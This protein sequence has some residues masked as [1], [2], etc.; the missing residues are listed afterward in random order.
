MSQPLAAT[1]DARRS[2]FA[3][4]L[5]LVILGLEL[6]DGRPG[7]LVDDDVWDLSGLAGVPVQLWN[8][9]LRWD[10][11][12]I[13]NPAWRW[14][15]RELLIAL[16]A[17]HDPRVE[18]LPRANRTALAP[19][20]CKGRFDA[21]VAWLN[22]L[23]AE[24]VSSLT[25]VDQHDCD[26][27][28][29][30]EQRRGLQESSVVGKI[31]AVID[32][33]RYGPLFS[34]DRYADG[35]VPWA[36]R[37]PTKVAGYRR[38]GE[39]RTPPV[40]DEIH[41][42]LVAAAR[43]IVE[44]IGPQ[45]AQ[46]LDERPTVLRAGG[47]GATLE[48]IRSYITR[49]VQQGSACSQI[50]A[51]RLR[52]RLYL[53]WHPDDPLLRLGFGPMRHELGCRDPSR[54][55]IEEIRAELEAAVAAV[56]IA[57]PL[58]RDAATVP[59]ADGSSQITWTEPLTHRE[60]DGLVTLTLNACLV[61]VAAISGMRSGELMELTPGS[62]LPPRPTGPGLVRYALR[63]RRIKGAPFGGIDDEWIVIEPA[64][65]AVEL[66]AGLNRGE[67]DAP[68]FGRFHFRT[69]LENF[70]RWVNSPGG[71]RLGLAPIPDGHVT[72]R[73]L[74]RTLAVE[75]AHRPHGLFAA[76]LH[77]KHISVAT[78]EG[79]AGRPGGSQ[80]RFHAEVAHE[81]RLHREAL[82]RAAFDEFREGRLP[83]GPGAAALIAAFREVDAQLADLK[84]TQPMIVATDRQI[85]LL[86]Q[87]KAATLYAQ[88]ANYCWF[89]DP[90]KALCLKIAGRPEAT[91]PLAG[92]CD[93]ARC[94]QA[95]VHAEHR[96]VWA[97]TAAT[98]E[99]FLANPRIPAAERK[100]LS[101]E[102]ER[103]LQVVNAI[104]AA[105]DSSAETR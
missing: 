82:T 24:G 66:A 93:A 40:A 35:F 75:L 59:A 44:V 64:Y 45:L 81:E 80:A 2:R 9:V 30:H 14:V 12:T 95:T 19:T 68:I 85:E 52:R 56:G 43:Y 98:T 26:R 101:L 8:A 3:G 1:D 18:L 4:E 32:L 53:G 78:T 49:H 88:A 20:T 61:L 34:T 62:C 31:Q 29:Q 39:N 47:R 58:A 86:L 51:H 60:F 103:A 46:R 99:M 70:R 63:A 105:T 69:K 74:R 42:P 57:P 37:T 17:P 54:P 21:L 27:F 7:P 41:G 5:V 65:R 90:A 79:Y 76:R 6:R 33:A 89:T 94:P 10:F 71:A 25:D 87:K 83:A 91:R 15:A 67:P 48:E 11:Q 96:Q 16:L 104:D 50:E 22:W 55:E 102:H 100:R 38:A 97:T 72:A 77:L 73:M 36:G 13:E 92:L 84:P 23:S 28:L